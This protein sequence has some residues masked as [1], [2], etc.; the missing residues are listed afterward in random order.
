MDCLGH[1]ET[2]QQYYKRLAALDGNACDCANTRELRIARTFDEAYNYIT[3]RLPPGAFVLAL[4]E[5]DYDAAIVAADSVAIE[6]LPELIDTVERAK[7]LHRSQI[8]NYTF[9]VIA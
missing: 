6:L 9:E 7:D 2:D 8:K 5:R 1:Q 4:V 3:H